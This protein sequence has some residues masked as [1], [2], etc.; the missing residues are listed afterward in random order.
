MN[1]YEKQQLAEL[2]QEFIDSFQLVFDYDWNY[3]K[4]S[5][6]DF[7]LI[8]E[9]GSF[10]NPFPGKFYCGGKGDNWANRSSFL[11]CYRKFKAY[12]ISEGF[13]SKENCRY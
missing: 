6:N 4:D 8:S 3:T 7:Y 11:S 2:I 12:C 1:N 10:L 9:K 13:Y 5:I